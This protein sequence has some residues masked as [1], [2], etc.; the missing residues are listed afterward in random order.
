MLIP[1][2][3]EE[4]IKWLD[5]LYPAK[6]IHAG[7]T[8]IDAHRYAAKRELIDFLL[9]KKAELEEDGVASLMEQN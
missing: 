4:L 1:H 2:S 6:C 9:V 8:E 7:Q 5:N 3:S